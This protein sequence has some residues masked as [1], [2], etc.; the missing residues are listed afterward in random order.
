MMV[1]KN[2]QKSILVRSMNLINSITIHIKRMKLIRGEG[3]RTVGFGNIMVIFLWL[4]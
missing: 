4:S 2:I 3:C 1:T